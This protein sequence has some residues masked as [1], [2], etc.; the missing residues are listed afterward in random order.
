MVLLCFISVLLEV[1]RW[2]WADSLRGRLRLVRVTRASKQLDLTSGD[3]LF[4]H[5][6][7][8]S[9]ECKASL[10]LGAKKVKKSLD[11]DRNG[12]CCV[13]SAWVLSWPG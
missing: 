2:V 10:C 6:Q 5:Q 12:C 3:D 4:C 9:K 13:V 1:E 8:S 7:Q 11:E